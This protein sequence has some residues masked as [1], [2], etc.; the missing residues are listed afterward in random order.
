MNSSS[1]STPLAEGNVF[2]TP[3]AHEAWAQLEAARA[4]LRQAWHDW[5]KTTTDAT[6]DRLSKARDAERLAATHYRTAIRQA[7]PRTGAAP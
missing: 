7:L 6:N 3:Q 5:L 2:E 1:E 4:E